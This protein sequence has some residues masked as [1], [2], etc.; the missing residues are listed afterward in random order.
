MAMTDKEMEDFFDSLGPTYDVVIRCGEKVWEREQ[1]GRI[2]QIWIYDGQRYAMVWDKET[3]RNLRYTDY[4]E[5]IK[6]KKERA[7][8]NDRLQRE[9]QK[10]VIPCTEPE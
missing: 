3:G 10:A 4:E 8:R 2:A 7:E 5:I 9:N 6:E 1:D